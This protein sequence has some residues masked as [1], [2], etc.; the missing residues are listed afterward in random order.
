MLFGHPQLDVRTFSSKIILKVKAISHLSDAWS[1]LWKRRKKWKY[2]YIL[3]SRDSEKSQILE[4]FLVV[5]FR[6]SGKSNTQYAVL[7]EWHWQGNAEVLTETSVMSATV[8]TTNFTWTGLVSSPVFRS[9]RP[10]AN[11]LS[12]RVQSVPRSKHTPSRL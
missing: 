8:S 2:Y 3:C 9:E 7:V 10:A 4:F 11:R 6:L 1:S 12:L 5:H